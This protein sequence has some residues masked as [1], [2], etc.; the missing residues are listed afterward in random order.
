MALL[1]NGLS[2][3]TMWAFAR[4]SLPY[5]QHASLNFDPDGAII[6]D[7]FLHLFILEKCHLTIFSRTTEPEKLLYILKAS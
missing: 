4:Y 3:S 5:G 1:I 7:T 6:G 2:I